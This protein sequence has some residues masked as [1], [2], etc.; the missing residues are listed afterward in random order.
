MMKDPTFIGG[1]DHVDIPEQ[2]LPSPL[3]AGMVE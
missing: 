2:V 1:F 3:L